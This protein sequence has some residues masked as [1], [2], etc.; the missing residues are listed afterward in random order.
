[1]RHMAGEVIFVDTKEQ[2]KFAEIQMAERNMF[3]ASVK[4]RTKDGKNIR[5]LTFYPKSLQP[6]NR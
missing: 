3:L 2:Q 1:M 5:V 4:G 6:I